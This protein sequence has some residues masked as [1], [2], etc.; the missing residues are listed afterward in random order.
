[1]T[2][3]EA[4]RIFQQHH[5][6]DPRRFLNTYF[7]SVAVKESLYKRGGGLLDITTWCH[8]QFDS[9][10]WVQIANKIW[11]SSQDQ[12]TQFWLTW[13]EYLAKDD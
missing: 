7:W 2:V 11:F 6:T 5:N 9:E 1:M 3:G 10:D 8:D 12:Y 4:L 13:E